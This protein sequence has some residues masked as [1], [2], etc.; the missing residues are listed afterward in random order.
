MAI[1]F[2]VGTIVKTMPSKRQRRLE[3]LRMEA[4]QRQMSVRYAPLKYQG[5]RKEQYLIS[6]AY[7]K[8]LSE[9]QAP[10]DYARRIS[11]LGEV[12]DWRDQPD[13]R[14]SELAQYPD[15]LAI[16]GGERRIEVCWTE[17]SIDDRFEQICEVLAQFK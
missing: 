4:R 8:G 13:E 1:A 12:E 10:F 15:I 14:F 2:V 17:Q 9:K 16:R 6:Y 5:T 11:P 3:A 7:G